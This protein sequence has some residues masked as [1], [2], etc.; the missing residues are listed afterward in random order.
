[1]TLDILLV[2]DEPSI[3]LVVGD[4]LR[5][6]GHRVVLAADGGEALSLVSSR[7]FDVVVTDIRL[8]KADGMTIFRRVKQERPQ[9]DVIL[10][11]AHGAVSD[12]VEA[13][14]EGAFDYLTKPFDPDE[15]AL[16]IGRIADRR[17]LER[18]LE[19]ARAVLGARGHATDIVGRSPSMLRLLERI[20]MI[21]ASDA[22]VLITGESG[23][24]KELVARALHER[25]PRRKKA[26]VAVNCAAFPETLIEA[27]LFG[28]ERGAFTGAVKRRDGRFKAAD[29]GTL[30]LDEVAEIPL[31]AQ[32]KLLRVLQ[33][34]MVE[35]LGTNDSVPVD[36][37]VISATHRSLKEWIGEGRFREDLYYR[38]NVLDIS[39]PPLRERRG[40]LP[41]LLEHFLRQHTPAGQPIPRISPRAWAALS[42]YAFPGNVR[43]LSH[44]IEHAIVLSRGREIDLDHLPRDIGGSAR[45]AQRDEASIRPLTVAMKEFEREYLVRTLALARNNRTRAADVLGISRKTLWEKLRFHGLS[46]AE[47]DEA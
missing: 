3:R 28:H 7:G 1:M 20:E 8:P 42:E 27:E 37:R 45:Y 25:S 24:G 14:K 44:A 26:F 11:T 4:T 34:G 29:G 9:T 13:L 41:L 16:R 30:L 38:V 33:Q 10:I 18:D 19:E 47:T 2:D 32:A 36:V 12:A 15:L 39:I 6:A 23:T 43:E 21:A 22:P 31:P 46:D 5:D 35:P 17:R 40:D